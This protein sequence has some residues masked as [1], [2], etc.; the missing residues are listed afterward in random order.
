MSKKPK[1]LGGAKGA[2][3]Q[4]NFWLITLGVVVAGFMAGEC[5]MW[6]RGGL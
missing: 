2:I 6:V 1:R 3:N 5:L 4:L